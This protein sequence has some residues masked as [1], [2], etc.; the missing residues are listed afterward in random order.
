MIISLGTRR[1]GLRRQTAIQALNRTIEGSV[2][3]KYCGTDAVMSACRQKLDSKTVPRPVCGRR[4]ANE[5]FER[6]R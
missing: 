3:G 5:R 4:Y 6:M 1:F 2:C